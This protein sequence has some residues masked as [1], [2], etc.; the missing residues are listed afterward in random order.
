[1]RL[2]PGLLVEH[3]GYMCRGSGTPSEG[4]GVNSVSEGASGTQH[5]GSG[6]SKSNHAERGLIIGLA[7]VL[8]VG[9]LVGGVLLIRR[10][11]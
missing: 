11:R 9:V 4:G 5:S 3:T 10:A 7:C 8:A 6:G 1:M 2:E